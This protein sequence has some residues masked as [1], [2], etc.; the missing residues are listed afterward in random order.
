[1]ISDKSFLSFGKRKEKKTRLGFEYLKL[2]SAYLSLYRTGYIRVTPTN[3]LGTTPPEP[4]MHLNANGAHPL[5]P[6]HT[7]TPPYMRTRGGNFNP[8]IQKKKK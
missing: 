2:A 7:A 6:T 1:M 3:V 5:L 8:F 4:L